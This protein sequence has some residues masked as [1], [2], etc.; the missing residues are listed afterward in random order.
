MTLFNNLPD[1]IFQPLAG[2]NRHLFEAV[3][4]GLYGRFYS[5]SA[6]APTKDAVM[7]SICDVVQSRGDLWQN[8]EEIEADGRS[9]AWAKSR[10]LHKHLEDCGWLVVSKSGYKASVEFSPVALPLLQALARIKEGKILRIEGVLQTLNLILAKLQSGENGYTV[11]LADCIT[12]LGEIHISMRGTKT[13][14]GEIRKEVFKI[15]G[16]G[17]RLAYLMDKYVAEILQHD[18]SALMRDHHPYRLKS[19]TFAVIDGFLHD[20]GRMLLLGQGFAMSHFTKIMEEGTDFERQEAVDR[21]IEM[22]H[23]G[24]SEIRIAFDKIEDVAKA[25]MAEKK[26]LD[27]QLMIQG[28]MPVAHRF[29]DPRQIETMLSEFAMRLAADPDHG[30]QVSGV[31]PVLIDRV[32][33]VSEAALRAPNVRRK[34]KATMVAAEVNDPVLAFRKQLGDEYALRIAPDDG[35]VAAYLER[36]T[37]A[38]GWFEF[39]DEVLR[40]VDDFLVVSE[41]LKYVVSGEA[42]PVIEERYA[43]DCAEDFSLVD[44]RYMKCPKFKVFRKEEMRDAA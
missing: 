21:G 22:A 23:R 28:T 3:L 1:R 43:F 38:G 31:P 24:F 20:K 26:K 39:S 41:L 11:A 18:I 6:D 25:I 2:K 5:D 37:A 30:E 35:K 29:G 33:H 12:H 13:R 17:A 42:P 4:M 8:D 40:D 19:R 32:S 36:V 7:A 16:A 44:T 27:Q 15:R 10:A 34:P 14:L 9:D